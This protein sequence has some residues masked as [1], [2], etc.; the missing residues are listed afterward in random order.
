MDIHLYLTNEPQIWKIEGGGPD[1]HI[2]RGIRIP[3]DSLVELVT[4]DLLLW[5]SL[6][7]T[8]KKLVGTRPRSKMVLGASN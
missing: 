8:I 4:L 1:L 7:E 2:Y 5:G 6:C 3:L